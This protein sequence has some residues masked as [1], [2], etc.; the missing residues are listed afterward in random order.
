MTIG[1]LRDELENWPEGDEIILR[2]TAIFDGGAFRKIEGI[3]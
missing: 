1:E 2:G 3:V